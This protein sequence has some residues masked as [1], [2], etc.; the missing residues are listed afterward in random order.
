[1]YVLAHPLAHQLLVRHLAITP[2]VHTST[3]TNQI[4][5]T[6]PHV[7]HVISSG[8]R[9]ILR[10]LHTHSEVTDLSKKCLLRHGTL[11]PHSAHTFRNNN[12]MYTHR[13]TQYQQ[14]HDQQVV[15]RL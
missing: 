5:I 11:A 13:L 3:I 4:S 1:M 7:S 12:C 2:T 14:L 10:V 6:R 8:P 15:T 9:A